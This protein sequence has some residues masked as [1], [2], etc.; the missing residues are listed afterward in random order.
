VNAIL[1]I[2]TAS[3]SLA[4]AVRDAAGEVRTLVRE[5]GHDH[6]RLLVPAIDEILGDSAGT[7]AGIVAVRGPGSYAG[8]RVGLA[9]ARALAFA[10]TVPLAGVTTFEAIGRLSE[11]GPWLAVHPVGRGTFA[12]QRIVDGEP[13]GAL[14]SETAESLLASGEQLIGEGAGA[15]GG[16]EVGPAERVQAALLAGLA[17][18]AGNTGG[19]DAVYLREPNITT[20]RR[21]LLA[22]R[23]N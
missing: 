10:R 20:P 3:P 12:A 5:C 9:T 17:R 23:T 6:S 8:I 19:V 16:R 11:S 7:L 1:A 22:A 13:V 18:L 2:D 14:S 15:L 4:L 21:P